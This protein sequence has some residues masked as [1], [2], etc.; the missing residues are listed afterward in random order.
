MMAYL[1]DFIEVLIPLGIGLVVT[2]ALVLVIVIAK[3]VVKY[4]DGRGK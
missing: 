2:L 4:R 1:L 3:A